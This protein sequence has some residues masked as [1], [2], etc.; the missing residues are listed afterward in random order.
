[1]AP[2]GC[3]INGATEMSNGLLHQNVPGRYCHNTSFQCLD[4][5]LPIDLMEVPLFLLTAFDDQ[6][7]ESN[8]DQGWPVLTAWKSSKTCQDAGYG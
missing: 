4:I 8:V 5:L 7:L 1:M 6:E 3:F 2:T